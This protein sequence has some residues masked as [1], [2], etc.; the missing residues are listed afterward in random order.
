M[1]I[2]II[3]IIYIFY[4]HQLFGQDSRVSLA[5]K[6]FEDKNYS[7]AQS[8]YHQLI[9]EGISNAEIEYFHARCSKELFLE[10]AKMLY[11]KHLDDYPYSQYKN[12]VYE[13]MA[14]IYF[15]EKKYN[16]VISFL[17]LIDDIDSRNDLIFKIAYASFC[18]DSLD[19]SL[20]YF[21]KLLDSNNKYTSA[22][23]YY[24]ACI[25]YSQTLYETALVNFKYLTEDKQFGRIIPYYISQI[26]FL[27]KDYEKLITS[28]EPYIDK[29]IPSRL[30]EMNWLLAEAFYRTKDYNKAVTYF[31][32]YLA[33]ESAP[34]SLVNFL[35]GDSYFKIGD[36]N[37]AINQ[38]EQLTNQP[39]SIMQCAIYYLGASYLELEHYSYALQA[40]KK[41]VTYDYNQQ[42][43]EDAFFHYAKLSYQLKL[44]FDNTLDVFNNYLKEYNNPLNVKHI[45]SL[46]VE[47]LQGTNQYNEAYIA[48][49]NI[50][51]PDIEQQKAIQ[52]LAFF[53]G[54]QAYNSLEYKKAIDYFNQSKIYNINNDFNF[55]SSFWLADSYY[56]LSNYDMAAKIYTSLPVNNSLNLKYYNDLKNY[57]LAYSYFK[58]KDYSLS[59]KYFRIYEKLSLDSMRLNDTYLFD[60][61]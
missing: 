12:Q 56:K 28:A 43:R 39:D 22:S 61:L 52:K 9:I 23:R 36:Y 13:D 34:E 4:S 2:R 21:S 8:L 54:V 19:A 3:L 18:V 14:L 60:K 50:Y 29:I 16:E 33:L 48:L 11:K 47:V 1:K 17:E 44:P 58:L 35:L 49:K 55:L 5:Q 37:N 24:Y 10:D 30:S 20:Y 31:N 59:N 41:V 46:M 40:F 26:Y 57:N 6:L 32:N 38:F 15:R 27:K 25:L 53:L 42:L 7:I 45:E 51:S